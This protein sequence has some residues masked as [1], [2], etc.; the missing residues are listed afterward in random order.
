MEAED[1]NAPQVEGEGYLE[2][3]VDWSLL[4]GY[5][6][7]VGMKLWNGVVSKYVVI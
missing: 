3:L 2:G 7:H 5:E 6:D 4:T 1:E